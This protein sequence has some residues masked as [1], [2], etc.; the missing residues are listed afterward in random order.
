MFD[1]PAV[2]LFLAAVVSYVNHRFFKLPDAVGVLLL[3]LVVTVGVMAL[4]WYHPPVRLWAEGFVNRL[5]FGETVLHGMLSFLL[6]AG[7][8]HVNLHDLSRSAVAIGTL[9]VV[10]T[11]LSTVVVGLFT[12]L[13]LGQL[14]IEAR[15][16][17]C[18]I[19]GAI[20]SP[21]DPIAV[22]GIIRRAG[23]ARHLKTTIVSQGLLGS[24]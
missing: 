22:L 9:A 18:M 7:A 24:M 1:I 13:L 20:I 21:T 12:W 4:G 5:D 8:L 14:E 19:F 15:L 23:I 2:L 17:Y 6:F 10:G 3:T 11:L 16:I